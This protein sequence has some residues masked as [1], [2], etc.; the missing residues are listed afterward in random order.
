MEFYNAVFNYKT[1]DSRSD[2]NFNIFNILD[3]EYDEVRLHSR[4]LKYLIEQDQQGFLE[5]MAI[6]LPE[7][8][9]FIKK[10]HLSKLKVSI[11]KSINSFEED[12]S[13]GRIDLLLQFDDFTIIIE[14]KIYA[15]DQE[16]QLIK[17]YNFIKPA[18]GNETENSGKFF[19]ILYLTPNGSPPSEHS[20]KFNDIN[21]DQNKDFFLIS[22]KH[23]VIKWLKNYEHTSNKLKEIIMQYIKTIEKICGIMLEEDKERILRLLSEH[24]FI[25]NFEQIKWDIG[26]IECKIHD[27]W[28]AVSEKINLEDNGIELKTHFKEGS[29]MFNLFSNERGVM[30][31]YLQYKPNFND[32][33]FLS[34]WL[35]SKK[36][37][38]FE[39]KKSNFNN[40]GFSFN[41]GYLN[42]RQDQDLFTKDKF[43]TFVADNN[44]IKQDHF[45]LIT[46]KI[47]Q[48]LEENKDCI[49]IL[50][51]NI[52]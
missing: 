19:L 16:S 46:D 12:L 34:I 17:Y 38:E 24:K 33:P 18:I 45:N 3:I 25:Q 13:D 31:F 37:K 21:L 27:F 51:E 9:S 32:S 47:I 48:Y 4:I 26:A 5:A 22:Y 23:H 15:R 7:N 40:I 28:R 43:I 36:Q 20:V 2:D 1:T 42:K 14:N 11:E 29:I 30:N 44:E 39:S 50:K 41:E 49:K 35:N 8:F 52:S 10:L 6:S